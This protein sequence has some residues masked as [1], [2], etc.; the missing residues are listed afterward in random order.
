MVEC[1]EGLGD[2]PDHWVARQVEFFTARGQRLEWKTYGYDEPADLPE[3]LVRAGFVPE[4][5]EVV[6]LAAAPTSCTTSSCREG[7]RL[8]EISTDDDWA[9]V[10]ATVDTVWGEDTSW[11]NDALRGRAAARPRPA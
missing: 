4:D 1:P 2:D 6:L 7:A 10:R 3:R 8:R 5:P 9:R 11:V